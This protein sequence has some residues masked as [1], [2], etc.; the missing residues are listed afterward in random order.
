MVLDRVDVVSE[1]LLDFERGAK[2]EAKCSSDTALGIVSVTEMGR[3]KEKKLDRPRAAA[4]LAMLRG[5]DHG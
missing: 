5:W 2:M 4:T 1:I 3:C